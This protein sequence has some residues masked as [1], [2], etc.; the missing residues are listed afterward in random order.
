[1]QYGK[2][3]TKTIKTFLATWRPAGGIIR[4]VLVQE[5]DGWGAFFCTDPHAS[6]VAGLGAMADRG[7]LEQTKKDGKEV[8]GAGQQQVRH[9]DS[10]VGCFNLNLWL[11][12]LVEV[13]AWDKAA[14]DLVDRSASPWDHE[15]RRPSHQDKRKAVQREVL[16]A[17]IHQALSGRPCK[18][19]MRALAQKLLDLAA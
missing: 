16:Q 2:Q 13:W 17:E 1:Q 10:N 4:V 19:K 9:L 12:T 7:A 8:W 5:D 18:G 3:V 14:E 6:A 11:Y 15:S